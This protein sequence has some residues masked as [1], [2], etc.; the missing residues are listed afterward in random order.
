MKILSYANFW[1]KNFNARNINAFTLAE[2][3]VVLL[4]MSIILAAM[5]PVMTTKMRSDN[6]QSSPWRWA[7]LDSIDAYFGVNN[8]QSAMLGQSTKAATDSGKLI[9]NTPNTST[10]A[11][12]F[13]LNGT[14][15]ADMY[16]G[17]NGMMLGSFVED[18]STIGSN[19][20]AL[21]RGINP[22]SSNGV[23]I[24]TNAKATR[25]NG[26]VI[27]SGATLGAISSAGNPVNYGEYS[28]VIGNNAKSG[29]DRGISIGSNA[30]SQIQS[31]D[32]IAIGDSAGNNNAGSHNIAIGYFAM[33]QLNTKVYDASKNSDFNLAIGD[34]VMSESTKGYS[35][36]VVGASA[37]QKAANAG[38]HNT[39]VGSQAMELSNGAYSSVAIG[40]SALRKN[41]ASNTAVG[42]VSMSEN[43]AG[44][45]NAAVGSY[46]LNQNTTGKDNVALGH[47]ALMG[48]TTGSYNTAIGAYALFK[49]EGGHLVG[50]T[51]G[52]NNTALGFYSCQWVTGSNK[53]CIGNYSGPVKG[54]TEATDN[55]KLLYLGDKDTTAIVPNQ[56][57]PYDSSNVLVIE[58]NVEITGA[59]YLKGPLI[60]SDNQM[61]TDGNGDM[62]MSD[63]R[64]KYVGT[65]STSGLDK[66]RQLKV[67]NY[68]YKKDDKKVPHVGVIAQDLQKVFPNA[69]KKGSDGFLTIRKEDM[70]Y[71]LINAVKELDA[72]I[73]ALTEQIKRH[74]EALAEVSR[75]QKQLKQAQD[76]ELKILRSTQND[77]NALRKEN[78]ELKKRLDKLERR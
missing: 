52:N 76:E 56:I 72:K 54:S 20:I 13:K 61:V 67:F 65:E 39:V 31:S 5:A 66:I 75:N 73:T 47:G 55:S 38:S 32:N 42:F 8:T 62:I 51:T 74:T 77:I 58:G 21:G 33:K 4:I 63:R 50:H 19:T 9:I 16:L 14:K 23:I 18:I 68:T 60:D 12:S 57:K 43:T 41:T 25:P 11:I 78:Q 2:M 6:S 22:S 53:T 70:F 24:G 29:S 15:T 17:S 46:S 45:E 59:L 37:M 40:T 36:T 28:V 30:G 69:V 26:V 1:H 49:D 10:P 34:R 48:N 71:A 7:G 35:N 3:M 27:G 44:Y 64:L